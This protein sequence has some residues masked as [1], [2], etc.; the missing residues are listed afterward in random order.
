MTIGSVQNLIS[1]INKYSDF[2]RASRFLVKF[3]TFPYKDT[4]K[5]TAQQLYNSY[6]SDSSLLGLPGSQERGE[7]FY[8]VT[9]Y[10]GETLELRCESVDMPGKTLN[11]FDHRTYGP[12]SKYPTQ[13][14]FSEITLNFLC[15]G[16]KRKGTTIDGVFGGAPLVG[17][18]YLE[19]RIFEDWINFIN[20]Y[21][22]RTSQ[23]PSIPYHNFRYKKDYQRNFLI[24]C[25]DVNSIRDGVVGTVNDAPDLAYEIVVV[26]AFPISM[27]PVQLSWANE[28]IARF[29]VTFAYERYHRS[30]ASHPTKQY[31]PPND[32]ITTMA[33]RNQTPQ[34]PIRSNEGI[35][36]GDAMNPGSTG[37]GPTGGQ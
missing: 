8:G 23:N 29:S 35:S 28:E 5:L 33:P 13:T 25:W 7:D 34:P 4:S 3:L 16:N 26:N 31:V 2:A 1:N 19:R 37:A 24:S 21:P 30:D 27:S 9:G 18:G 10:D 17:T 20:P 12:I 15:S 32:V 11:T 36:L 22:E 6:T 14:F